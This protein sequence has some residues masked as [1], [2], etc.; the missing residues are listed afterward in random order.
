MQDYKFA[1]LPKRQIFSCRSVRR[2][3]GP[4]ADKIHM[5]DSGEL[6][7][8]TTPGT[9][10]V[11]INGNTRQIQTPALIWNREGSF[12][13]LLEISG[14]DAD[15]LVCFYKPQVLSEIPQKLR[16]PSLFED[17]DQL[18]LPLTQP[19]LETFLPLFN[20]LKTAPL[21]Q[22]RFLI[23]CV[24][25]QMHQLICGGLPPIR[26]GTTLTY[27]FEVAALLQNPD[28][29][30]L[31]LEVLA[32]RFHVSGSKLKADFKRV[33]NMPIHSFRRHV[34][35]QSARILLET[36]QQDLAQISYSCGFTDESYFI[37]AFRK[38]Y[39]ITPGNYRK[40]LKKH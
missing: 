37:R 4:S 19:Q 21:S 3:I 9:A 25:D 36:S 5:H 12:H 34:Q 26:S 7:L 32:E 29:D 11:F 23:L 40:Q 10:A 14:Q 22:A 30:K 38:E 2:K 35:L 39:G 31:T 8:I 18:I 16:Y 6:T 33:T 27:I 15:C 1:Y 13:E 17:S 20:L 28:Q 24:F